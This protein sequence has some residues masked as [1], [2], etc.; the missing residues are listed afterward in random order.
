MEIERKI[1][2][3]DLKMV[4]EKLHALPAKEVFSGL[5]RVKYFDY[6]D[7][8]IHK[9]HELLR[10]RELVPENGV[11]KTEFVC[12][13]NRKIVNDCKVYDEAELIFERE[14]SFQQT[15]DFL[16]EIGFVQTMYFEKRRREFRYKEWKF[17]LDEYP[18]IPPL[19]EIESNSPEK[20]KE[21]ILL[22]QLSGYP[23]TPDTIQ[24]LMKNRYQQVE[25]NGL[26]F[27]P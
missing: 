18:K 6:P 26:T 15:C 1:L 14:G 3:I 17:E 9:A 23:Q 19:L 8:R 20:V 12:K 25:L 24:E 7:G 11:T 4:L 2:E 21:A 10:V 16:L 22:L 13:T 27:M 5:M